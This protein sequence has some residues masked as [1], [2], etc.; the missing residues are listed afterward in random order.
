MF[1][2]TSLPFLPP[3]SAS[4]LPPLT[5]ASS[6]LSA[7]N[8]HSAAHQQTSRRQKAHATALQ[9]NNTLAILSADERTIAQRKMAIAMYGYSWLKPAGCAK[10]MLGRREEE[11]EREEVERQLREVELQERMQQEA[12][13]QDRLA[14]LGETGEPGEGR[15]LDEDIPDA[16]ADEQGDE[17]DG[18]ELSDEF[19]DVD[20]EDGMEG[21]LDDEIP[22]ADADD[23]VEEDEDDDE[24]MSPEAETTNADW[25]YDTRREPDTDEDEAAALSPVHAAA[26]VRMHASASV[27]GVYI[28]NRGSDRYDNYDERDAEDLADAMLDEDEIFEDR[29]GTE[30]GERDL[31]DDIPEAESEQAWE[32]TDTELDESEMDISIL[33]GTQI[34]PAHQRSSLLGPSRRISSGRQ[35]TYPS[36]SRRVSQRRSS[37]PWIIGPSVGQSPHPH[38]HQEVPDSAHHGYTYNRPTPAA[39]YVDTE[40]PA[41][42]ISGNRAHAHAHAHA[43]AQQQHQYI[44]TPAMLD[45]PL[46]VDAELD[47]DLDDA[48]I[49]TGAR[50]IGG[51]ATTSRGVPV[52]AGSDSL[53]SRAGAA[54]LHGNENPSRATAARNWLDGAAAA[55]GGSARRTLFGRAVRRGNAVIASAPVNA[56]DIETTT[57]S[58]GI[59]SGGL[60]T[61]SPAVGQA[62]G[63]V[64]QDWETPLNR[65]ASQEGAASQGQG[66]RETR[67]RSGRLLGGRTRR[68]R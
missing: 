22:D 20:E 43:Q 28:A 57:T 55:V 60:F 67:S 11:L 5:N 33:P 68:E 31:D 53:S 30:P 3:P 1:L 17:D 35:S 64:A 54:G 58:T 7:F 8:Q 23:G 41:R 9:R 29:R 13:E 45:S 42:V 18:E 40:G 66:Q 47:R 16:D 15:D 49:S 52:A 24:I 63:T 37:G 48:F 36:G 25:V 12:D 46:E 10:T 6:D 2:T 59:S 51:R 61:P 50:G 26:R 19:E 65:Q 21:D 39:A 34:Q 32:H 14:Q 56:A 38:G 27:A 62:E 4:L 44:Q